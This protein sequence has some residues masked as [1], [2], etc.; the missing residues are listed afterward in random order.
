VTLF[1]KQVEADL[2]H[3][4]RVEQA[5]ERFATSARDQ[6][7]ALQVATTGLFLTGQLLKQAAGLHR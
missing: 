3:A 5:L 2:A 1:R 6:A 4:P 7:L